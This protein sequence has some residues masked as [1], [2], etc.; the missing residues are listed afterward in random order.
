MQTLSSQST[1]ASFFDGFTYCLL[2]FCTLL[3]LIDWLIGTSRRERLQR[4]V[5]DWWV[6]VEDSSV[7]TFV[8]DDARRL[9]GLH[10]R[11][12]HDVIGSQF[13]EEVVRVFMLGAPIFLLGM[14][15]YLLWFAPPDVPLRS[16]Q[17][18]FSAHV[19]L[20]PI[21]IG[22]TTGVI[23]V[24]LQGLVLRLLV[25]QDGAGAILAAVSAT[26][27]Y[28]AVVTIMIATGV[29]LANL[30]EFH[31]RPLYQ[32]NI[33]RLQPPLEYALR[34]PARVT[35]VVWQLDRGVTIGAVLWSA[36]PCLVPLG[37][38]LVPQAVFT[39]SKMFRAVFKPIL[40]LLL[41]RFYE[42]KQGILTTLAIGGGA[43][44]K[45]AQETVK[46]FRW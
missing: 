37:F 13:A 26:L 29:V 1:S 39:V 27:V 16:D 30:Y 8:S 18:G 12:F 14:G 34:I 19:L 7:G 46:H 20:A 24:R 32:Q 42:S 17:T 22:V 31:V 40:A 15:T 41:G 11:L 43:F 2:V 6:Y 21:V 10:D 36:G 45:L 5:G 33:V 35:P 23:G 9:L 28:V 3:T 44:A 25:R 38:L 4:K